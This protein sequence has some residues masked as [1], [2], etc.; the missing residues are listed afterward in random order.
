MLLAALISLFVFA[1]MTPLVHLL[2]FASFQEWNAFVF[3]WFCVMGE[4]IPHIQV[5]LLN[6]LC[7][8]KKLL[9]LKWHLC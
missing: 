6:L 9:G 7:W 5:P 8:P 2:M 3:N 1:N 4:I